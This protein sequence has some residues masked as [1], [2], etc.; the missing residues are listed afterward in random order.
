MIITDDSC[1][2]AQ[3]PENWCQQV[4]SLPEESLLGY[5]WSRRL[6]LDPNETLDSVGAENAGYSK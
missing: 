6:L 5:T 3:D 4:S 1:R 2:L